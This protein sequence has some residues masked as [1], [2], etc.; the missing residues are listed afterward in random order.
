MTKSSHIRDTLAGI[1]DG[2]VERHARIKTRSISLKNF[3]V[4]DHTHFQVDGIDLYATD[5]LP[6]K[7]LCSAIGM[8]AGFYDKNPNLLNTTIFE[9]RFQ[10]ME[11]DDATRII[12]YQQTQIGNLLMAIL[13]IAH[14][15]ANYADVLDPLVDVIP[16]NSAIRL[17]NH[18]RVDAEHRLSLRISLLDYPIPM[19]RTDGSPEPCELGFFVDMSEDGLSGKMT[20]TSMLYNQTCSN[21]AMVT[22]DSHPYF[23]YNYRGI[24]AV[25]LSA[26]IKSAIGRFGE[27]VAF[28]H[29]KVTESDAKSLSKSG[30][31]G[32]LKGL[33]ARRDVSLGFIRKVR[34]EVES[35]NVELLS[36]W[37]VVNA[38]TFGAQK[39]NYDQRVRHEFVAGHLLGLNV[40][41]EAA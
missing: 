2:L 20:M 36:R 26:A 4:L 41:Q 21:G 3:K 29:K 7:H 22:Y 38:I 23:S 19:K 8:G 16:E 39:L 13:P 10:A 24:R 14:Q 18:E 6:I 28:L 32:F 31:L 12:R 37:R 17:S 40:L 5:N 35:S 9:T 30:A 34:A 1:R 27:D 25:D 11:D 33:E 15:S